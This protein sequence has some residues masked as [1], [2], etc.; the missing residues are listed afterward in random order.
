[1]I[2]ND[3]GKIVKHQWQDLICRFDN[4]K[5]H[6]FIV[7]PNHF[8]GIVEIVGVPQNVGEP[9]TRGHGPTLGNVVGHLN[10]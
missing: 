6:E 2:L 8:H 1:M 5:L 7:M 10:H 3:A 4:I 9:Q